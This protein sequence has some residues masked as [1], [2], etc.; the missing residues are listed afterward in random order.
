MLKCDFNKAAKPF[1]EITLQHKRFPVTFVRIF[2][3]SLYKNFSGWLLLKHLKTAIPYL[4]L[5]I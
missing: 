2:R 1:T 4:I 3:T 5:R